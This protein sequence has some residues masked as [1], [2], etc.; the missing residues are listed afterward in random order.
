MVIL[1][2]QSALLD[3]VNLNPETHSEGDILKTL[4]LCVGDWQTKSIPTNDHQGK[5]TLNEA[6]I[7][8]DSLKVFQTQVRDMLKDC[9]PASSLDPHF[10]KDPFL[11]IGRAVWQSYGDSPPLHIQK[12]LKGRLDKCKLEFDFN[13]Q[14]FRPSILNNQIE[15]DK[16]DWELSIQVAPTLA[17]YLSH[18]S[19]YLH[20]CRECEAIF[21]SKQKRKV[22]C[23]TTCKDLWWQLKRSEEGYHKLYMWE[24]RRK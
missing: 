23:G 3:F 1:P 4:I 6:E 12:A 16:D 22:F 14:T 13:Q 21:L 11:V 20:R 7:T 18:Y 19:P 8:L 2:W 24:K 5:F 15:A 9:I 17:T 10:Y